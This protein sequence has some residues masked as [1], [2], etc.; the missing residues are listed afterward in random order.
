MKNSA[1]F[2]LL[3]HSLDETI[4][5][6]HPES[7]KNLLTYRNESLAFYGKRGDIME[8][9]GILTVIFLVWYFAKHEL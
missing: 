2:S 3:L 7:S 9:L 8:F 4:K 1:A 5:N 6:S